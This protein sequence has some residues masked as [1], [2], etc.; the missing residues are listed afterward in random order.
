MPHFGQ[1][2]GR[3]LSTPEHIGQM[4]LCA[5]SCPGAAGVSPETL[6]PAALALPSSDAPL[7]R[8]AR[9]SVSLRAIN[10]PF[11]L[12]ALTRRPAGSQS[13]TPDGPDNATYLGG[14]YS[15][16]TGT[17]QPVEGQDGNFVRPRLDHRVRTLLDTEQTGARYD[18]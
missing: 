12:L 15:L 1:L 14:G 10:C 7:P 9:P 8:G 13:E 16:E 3:S 4:Y 2:P 11:L 5:V 18:P 6:W 17:F